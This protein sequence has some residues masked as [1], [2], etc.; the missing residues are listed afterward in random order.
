[1]NAIL[2]EFWILLL[3]QGVKH[4]VDIAIGDCYENANLS[5]LISTNAVVLYDSV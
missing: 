1:V 2:D 5:H 4:T 3:L